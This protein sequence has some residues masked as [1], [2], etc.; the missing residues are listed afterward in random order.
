MDDGR[1]DRMNL[2]RTML[3]VPAI[4]AALVIVASG[5]GARFG[6]W[7][8]SVGFRMLTYGAYAG[9]AVAVIAL[10]MLLIPRTRAGHAGV[11]AISLVVALGAAAM[12]LYWLHEARTLPPINDI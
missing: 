2:M 5:F 7:H 12:P 10:V 11:L 9:I 8:F 3:L 4:A 6:V 1:V